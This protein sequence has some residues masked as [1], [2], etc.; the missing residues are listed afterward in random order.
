MGSGER[1]NK[2]KPES[3]EAAAKINISDD[4]TTP[5]RK[6]LLIK[7]LPVLLDTIRHHIAVLQRQKP[8]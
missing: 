1:R 7:P 6:S 3:G 8:K 2:K 4:M 5:A